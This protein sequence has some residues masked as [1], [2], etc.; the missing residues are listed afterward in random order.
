MKSK[1]ILLTIIIFLSTLFI[2]CD[3]GD[4]QKPVVSVSVEP[5]RTL[6]KAIV[7]DRYD[8]VTLLGNG[9]DPE[10]YDPGLQTRMNVERS[11]IYFTT[12]GMPFEEKLAANLPE[13]VKIVDTSAGIEPVYGTHDH[14][15]HDHGDH[16][17][18]EGHHNGEKDPHI[19]ASLRNARTMAATMCEAMS[20]TDPDNA[21]YYKANLKVLDARLDSLD[22]LAAERLGNA[23]K[24]FAIWH[25]S[26]S[27][28]ARDYGLEQV[29]VGF[30][31]KEMSPLQLAKVAE[32]A[33]EKGIKVF[34]FQKEYDSRQATSLNKEMGTRLVTIEPLAADFDEQLLKAATEL[35]R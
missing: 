2:S 25:P 23:P 33:H 5:Q 14:G 24:A 22:R 6:L 9:S 18:H 12:G 17:G 10:S 32:T 35:T 19:W 31:N 3:K 29:S 1:Y 11:D 7:G 34:F 28:F 16:D 20:E 26:L 4:Q 15:D 30:E 13:S 27:Y 21:E 8:V